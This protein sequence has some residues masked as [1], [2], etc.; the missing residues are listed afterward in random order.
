VLFVIV[1]GNG[2]AGYQADEDLVVRLDGAKHVGDFDLGN[3]G[4]PG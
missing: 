3:F 4:T 2:V 1:D